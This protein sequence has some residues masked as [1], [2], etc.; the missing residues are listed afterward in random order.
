MFQIN[1]LRWIALLLLCGCASMGSTPP[2][3][4]GPRRQ[5]AEQQLGSGRWPDALKTCR[6]VLRRNPDDCAARYCELIGQTMLFVD[7]LNR[8]VLPR[9]RQ[10]GAAGL[11][12]LFHLCQMQR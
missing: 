8:Y 6:A 5:L 2:S 4:V 10:G 1:V 7:Q 3:L 9:Y 11:G 12:D